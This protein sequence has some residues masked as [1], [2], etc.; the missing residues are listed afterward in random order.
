MNRRFRKGSLVIAALVAFHLG[1]GAAPRLDRAPR[2]VEESTRGTA[3]RLPQAWIG[4][5]APLND[6]V[7]PRPFKLKGAGIVDLGS[8]AFL[9][10]GVATHFGRYTADGVI[11]LGTFSIQGTFTAADSDTLDWTAQFGIGPLGEIQV[12]F[13]FAGGTGRFAGAS[14]SA[15][16]PVLLD[17]DFMFVFTLEGTISY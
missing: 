9:F 12:T 17:P 5:E 6:E 10:S 11:D 16:G 1:T 13:T 7:V 2:P 14:G 15:S 3:T 4:T 8:A